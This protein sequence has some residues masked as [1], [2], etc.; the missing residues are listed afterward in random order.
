MKRLYREMTD[1]QKKAIS[2][3]LKGRIFTDSHKQAIS[4]A[5]KEYWD[6][7]PYKN[8]SEVSNEN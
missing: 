2:E 7:I 6:K 1:T 5:L 3:A 8:E 4:K